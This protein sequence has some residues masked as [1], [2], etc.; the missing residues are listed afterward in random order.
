MK[1]LPRKQLITAVVVGV[2]GWVTAA[3][4]FAAGYQWTNPAGGRWDQSGNWSVPGYPSYFWDVAIFGLDASY[5]VDATFAPQVGPVAGVMVARGAVDLDAPPVLASVLAVGTQGYP[6]SLTLRS[7]AVTGPAPHTVGPAGTLTLF[8]GTGLL[9]TAGGSYGFT[10]EGGGTLRGDGAVSGQTLRNLGT[11]SPGLAAGDP[12]VLTLGAAGATG[13]DQRASGVLEID[14][15]GPDPGTGYDRLTVADGSLG[16]MLAGTLRVRL[17]DGYRPQDGDRFTVFTAASYTGQFSILDLPEEPGLTFEVAYEP[18]GVV[19]QAVGPSEVP[20]TLDVLPGSCPNPLSFAQ[21]GVLPAAVVGTADFDVR[22][23]DPASL[24]LAGAPALRWSWEDVTGPGEDRCAAS[25]PDGIE[26]LVLKF[27][28]DQ[29]V[30]AIGEAGTGDV[31]DLAL[32]GALFDGTALTG[33]DTVWMRGRPDA[34]KGKNKAASA[35]PELTA[36][37]RPGESLQQVGYVMPEAGTARITVF[38]VQGRRTAILAEGAA[39]AGEHTATWN[40]AGVAR[41]IYFVILD[42]DRGRATTRITVLR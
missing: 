10:V 36:L 12:G 30:A 7:G 23:V 25:G 35:R 9:C 8:P 26:D 6:A 11:V 13:Y 42:T 40:T 3:P 24:A 38:D 31:V 20:V 37:S 5:T 41:G 18:D 27:P 34:G 4:A 21:K 29:V 19:V 17:A 15:A 14:L 32:T 2:L 39:P 28:A 33:S 22:T 16:V 1:A